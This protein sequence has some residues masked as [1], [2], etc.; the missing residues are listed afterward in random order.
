MRK[1]ELRMKELEK[2][3]SHADNHDFSFYTKKI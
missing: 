3:E 2:Y 1:I